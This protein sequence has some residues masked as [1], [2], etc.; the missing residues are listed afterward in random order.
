MAPEPR[1]GESTYALPLPCAYREIDPS[2]YSSV[3]CTLSQGYRGTNVHYGLVLP[4]VYVT[5]PHYVQQAVCRTPPPPIETGPRQEPSREAYT[6]DPFQLTDRLESLRVDEKGTGMALVLSSIMLALTVQLRVY[7]SR[8][9]SAA[10]RNYLW[11]TRIT[12]KIFRLYLERRV[13]KC[14]S[15]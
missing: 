11:K 6:S 1:S 14:A 10:R 13:R 3:R 7:E 2:A 5:G 4:R 8:P 15:L 9:R 12:I